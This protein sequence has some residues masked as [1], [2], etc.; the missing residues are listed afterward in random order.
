MR[1][2]CCRFAVSRLQLQSC[3]FPHQTAYGV[4]PVPAGV[5][6]GSLSGRLACNAR[7]FRGRQW[8]N[9][10]RV[11]AVLSSSFSLSLLAF[12][13]IRDN[14]RTNST[15]GGQSVGSSTATIA[16]F[17]TVVI[18]VEWDAASHNATSHASYSFPTSATTLI[19]LPE[20]SAT[21]LLFSSEGARPFKQFRYSFTRKLNG[22]GPQAR[23]TVQRAFKDW[24]AL[25]C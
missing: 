7:L 2:G 19:R 8:A 25:D 21:A 11:A 12:V 4:L 23:Q 18:T 20:T 24:L 15:S 1:I 3:R 10:S 22:D 16:V 5:L 6:E 14:G 9:G 13:W 17:P